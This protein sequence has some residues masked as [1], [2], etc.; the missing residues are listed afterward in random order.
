MFAHLGDL[1]EGGAGA[2]AGAVRENQKALAGHELG[3]GPR[4]GPALGDQEKGVKIS[5][6]GWMESSWSIELNK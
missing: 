1:G 5:E 4:L 3:C 2:A 6:S